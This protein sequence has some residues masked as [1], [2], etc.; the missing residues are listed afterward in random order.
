MTA[1]GN[2]LR[3]NASHLVPKAV[4]VTGSIKNVSYLVPEAIARESIVFFPKY[5]ARERAKTI[6]VR[7]DHQGGSAPKARE[8]ARVSG[9]R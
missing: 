7:F 4:T 5:I 3:R 6:P 2:I 9:P 1:P 8:I